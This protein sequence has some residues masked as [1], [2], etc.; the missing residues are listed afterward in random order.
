DFAS[1]SAAALAGGI[2]TIGN[3]TFPMP[4]E[5]PLAS[6]GRETALAK[7]QAIADVFLHPV[8]DNPDTDTLDEIPGLLQHGCSSIKIFLPSARF[9]SNGAAFTEAIRRAGAGGLMSMLHCEDAA[10]LEYAASRLEG[11]GHSSLQ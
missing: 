4:G 1:G 5:G 2:T 7:Q 11:A 8:L 6:L 9:D 10:L 3:M